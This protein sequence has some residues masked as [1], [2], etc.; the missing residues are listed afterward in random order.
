MSRPT[1][2]L[3]YPTL[4][5]ADEIQDKLS[6]AAFYLCSIA[7]DRVYFFYRGEVPASFV[8]PPGMDPSIDVLVDELRPRVSFIREDDVDAMRAA[9]DDSAIIFRWRADDDTW[10]QLRKLSRTD[11][12]DKK[13]WIVDKDARRT[14]STLFVS[15]VFEAHPD[16]ELILEKNR[17]VFAE[18][19]ARLGRREKA[20]LFGT[21][22]SASRYAEFDFS[23][24]ISIVCNTII[25]DE[26]L[27]EHV[28][29]RLLVFADHI[30]HFGPSA[31]AASFREM[32]CTAAGK[33][34]LTILIPL[35]YY[36]HLCH[37]C[38]ELAPR[39]IGVPFDRS[40]EPNLDLRKQFQLWPIDNILTLFLVPLGFTFAR[41][42]SII[43]CDGRV[44]ADQG[45]FWKHN[46]KTQIG[47]LYETVRSTHPG[48]FNV[49]YEDYYDRHCENLERWLQAA[50]AEGVL[51]QSLVES[52]IPALRR[53]PLSPEID[54]IGALSQPPS[55]RVI[56]IDPDADISD[57]VAVTL[58]S[59]DSRSNVIPVFTDRASAVN[60]H[61]NEVFVVRFGRQLEACVRQLATHEPATPHLFTMWSASVPHLIPVLKAAGLVSPH[62]N[63]FVLN[64]QVDP[65]DIDQLVYTLIRT[66]DLRARRNVCLAVDSD[67]LADE[68]ERLAGERPLSWPTLDAVRLLE[69]AG[70]GE[71]A[72]LE[73]EDQL[74]DVLGDAV[75]HRRARARAHLRSEATRPPQVNG[76]ATA[77]VAARSINVAEGQVLVIPVPAWLQGPRRKLDK[78]VRDPRRFFSDSRLPGMG[79]LARFFSGSQD[80]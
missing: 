69:R 4:T 60:A 79:A 5:S 77:G 13:V 68:I 16:R 22:P 6:R 15:A 71:P 31:Y 26:A 39:L 65:L 54:V 30:F 51:C 37:L 57:E 14:E 67:S 20:Y 19:A 3:F 8:S 80:R 70:S 34:D 75:C 24:G 32:A 21:G 59:I 12:A 36:A 17:K 58:G 64:L 53:R 35:K 2:V 66:R 76:T 43:G 11:L 1:S 73:A 9:V 33:Y 56:N 23:D 18:L 7:V 74:L 47:E 46:A 29:P 61:N 38:P 41:E 25:R 49:D 78:L 72:D 28:R 50:E 40:I 48:F 45:S 52:H 55:H 44:P 10:G 42:I 63:A 27:M 62:G